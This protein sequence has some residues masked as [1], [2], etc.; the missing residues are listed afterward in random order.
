M[1]C[2]SFA[3]ASSLSENIDVTSLGDEFRSGHSRSNRWPR[4]NCF[5][6]FAQRVCV[7][8]MEDETNGNELPHFLADLAQ[9]VKFGAEFL[10]FFYLHKPDNID[11]KAV[12]QEAKCIVTNVAFE[13]QPTQPIAATIQ[14]VT[15]RGFALRI[16]FPRF[17]ILLDGTVRAVDDLLLTEDLDPIHQQTPPD[18]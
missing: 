16:G 15:T 7:E 12:W 18:F 5:W 3:T 6:D 9:R 11:E 10:G 13:I 14:F 8:G 2:P 1:S 17:S 4:H